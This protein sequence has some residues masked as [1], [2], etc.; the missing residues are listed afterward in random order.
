MEDRRLR[1]PAEVQVDRASI[2]TG[3]SSGGVG[4]SSDLRAGGHCRR[5][6]SPSLPSHIDQ[7]V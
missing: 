6:Y 5:T 3:R 7:C 4:R 2:E 1:L